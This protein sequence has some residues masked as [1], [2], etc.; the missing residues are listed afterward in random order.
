MTTTS[1]NLITT[2]TAPTLCAYAKSNFQ[3]Y[4]EINGKTPAG[5]TAVFYHRNPLF[6]EFDL[7]GPS[8]NIRQIQAGWLV[9]FQNICERE[10]GLYVLT[11]L[12]IS[13]TDGTEDFATAELPLQVIQ[14]GANLLS[15]TEVEENHKTVLSDRVAR[16]EKGLGSGANTFQF[17]YFLIDCKVT[18]P[19][20]L[21]D[22]ILKPFD[23]I[24][25]SDLAAVMS[26]FLSEQNVQIQI[27]EI[28]KMLLNHHHIPITLLILPKVLANSEKEAILLADTEA[29][30]LSDV[31][32][33]NRHGY[34]EI[35]GTIAIKQNGELLLRGRPKIYRGN[36]MGGDISG[37]YKTGLFSVIDRV[38]AKPKVQLYLSLYTSSFQEEKIEF[39]YF[40]LWS[41]LETIAKNKSYIGKPRLNW[42]GIQMTGGAGKPLLIENQAEQLVFELLR[43]CWAGQPFTESQNL[44]QSAVEEL[45]PIWYRHRNC[46]GHGGGCFPNDPQF[47]DTKIVKFS[48]CKA[49]HLE[50]TKKYGKRELLADGY[51]ASLE[52]AVRTVVLKEL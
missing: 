24:G 10:L 25:I 40:R 52:T 39:R 17:I 51:L 23:K 11:R 15:N 48:K 35:I 27:F 28:E 31:V 9:E 26:R 34:G 36:L 38:R 44:N 3:I 50:E 18:V 16:A 42:G 33:I 14:L 32:S 45:V 43:E 29:K 19:L 7:C 8:F 47:C 13:F 30:L 5:L 4:I 12:N 22:F 20:D 1:K 21:Y 46:V 49:A 41:L 37:E 2:L 6:D